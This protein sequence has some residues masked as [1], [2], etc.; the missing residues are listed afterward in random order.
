MSAQ[1]LNDKKI[2]GKAK[3]MARFEKSCLFFPIINSRPRMMNKE[4][5]GMLS[6]NTVSLKLELVLPKERNKTI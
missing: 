1:S 6:L 5:V 2:N 3:R 4:L